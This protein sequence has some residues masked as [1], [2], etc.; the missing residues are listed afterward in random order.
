MKKS[1][2]YLS[3]LLILTTR[4]VAQIEN[5]GSRFQTRKHHF[6]ND[7]LMIKSKDMNTVAWVLLGAGSVLLLAGDLVYQNNLADAGLFGELNA[8]PGGLMMIVGAGSIITSVPLFIVSG[9]YKQKAMK[10]TAN[11]KAERNPWLEQ[12]SKIAPFYPAF[13]VRINF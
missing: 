8:V 10:V 2:F 12:A 4:S 1:I 13:T 3:V 6:S 7:E 5:T 9:K 11:L